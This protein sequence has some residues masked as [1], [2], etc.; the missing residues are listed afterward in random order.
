MDGIEVAIMFICTQW[1][2]LLIYSL[3][4]LFSQ[5]RYIVYRDKVSEKFINSEIASKKDIYNKLDL[6][7]STAKEFPKE[8]SIHITFVKLKKTQLMNKVVTVWQNCNPKKT[9]VLAFNI[10]LLVFIVYSI[11]NDNT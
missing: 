2:M 1:L 5:N 7:S 11:E 9:N 4:K 3:Y 10:T 8:T 6:S